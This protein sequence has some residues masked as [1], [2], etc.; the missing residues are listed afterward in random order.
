M[1][2]LPW[3]LIC[4]GARPP[5]GGT[6][7]AVAMLHFLSQL[8]LVLSAGRHTA[9]RCGV[10]KIHLQ[11]GGKQCRRQLARHENLTQ[12]ECLAECV[13]VWI[14]VALQSAHHPESGNE[15]VGC[16]VLDDHFRTPVVVGRYGAMY[17]KKDISG[18]LAAIG[19][20]PVDG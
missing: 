3:K 13:E 18:E 16:V 4:T 12:F 7:G 8:L 9:H 15:L 11:A 20:D 10:E 19:E 14:E 5:T 1:T 2:W 6:W 17:V